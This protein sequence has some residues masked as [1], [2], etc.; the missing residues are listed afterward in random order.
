MAAR[1]GAKPPTYPVDI[2]DSL[3]S[4]EHLVSGEV[5]RVA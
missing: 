4:A 1:W 2:H 5:E 3:P